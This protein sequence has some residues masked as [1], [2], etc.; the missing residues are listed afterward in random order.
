MVG[1]Y[2]IKPLQGAKFK[3]FGEQIINIQPD[4]D[5]SN[6]INVLTRSSCLNNEAIIEL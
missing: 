3:K 5:G 4:Y 2:F 1:G 6:Q